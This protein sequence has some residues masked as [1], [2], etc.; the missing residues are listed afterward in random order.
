MLIGVLQVELTI[1]GSQSLKDKRRVVQSIKAKLHREHMVSVAETGSLGSLSTATLGIVLAAGEV[2]YCQS[3][4]HTIVDK[5]KTHRDAVLADWSI[6]IIT[7]VTTS[8][9]EDEE[10]LEDQDGAEA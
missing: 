9:T 4:L 1:P 2:P 6:Q 5:L 8:E 10:G 7:G 3:V